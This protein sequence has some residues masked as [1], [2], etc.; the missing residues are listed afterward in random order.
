MD[1]QNNKKNQP[2]ETFVLED[3]EGTEIVEDESDQ[4]DKNEVEEGAMGEAT[5]NAE[6]AEAAENAEKVVDAEYATPNAT[7]TNEGDEEPKEARYAT[8]NAAS[9]LLNLESLINGYIV[10]ME[11]LQ[12]QIKTQ[13][14]MFNDAFNNDAEFSQIM[15]KVKDINR[16]KSAA[17]QRIM[18]LPN[19]VDVSNRMR[20]YKEELKDIQDGLSTYLQQYKELSGSNQ[21][22]RDNGEVVEIVSTTKL[23]KRRG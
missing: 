19:V 1:D 23:V 5:E 12:E 15:Q 9:S 22:T 4:F 8:P 6:N 18:K 7:Q 14:D 10:D 17:K 21:I 2:D 16:V 3:A 13:R 20:E 11:K